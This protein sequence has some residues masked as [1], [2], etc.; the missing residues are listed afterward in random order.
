MTTPTADIARAAANRLTDLDPALPY[1]VEARLQAGP[2]HAP[3]A[4]YTDLPG[5]AVALASLLVSTVTLAL[6]FF[7]PRSTSAKASETAP[8]PAALTRRIRVELE[9]P[10]GISEAQRDR[11][12]A[13]VVEEVLRPRP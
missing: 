10:A 3:P 6:T 2:D 5:L 8:S 11:I 9:I 7:P 4:R 1:L 13:T 12:I